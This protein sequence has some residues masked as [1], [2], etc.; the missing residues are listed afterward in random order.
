MGFV[1]NFLFW[2]PDAYTGDGQHRRYLLGTDASLVIVPET[3][4]FLPEQHE[5]L[6]T[7]TG[8]GCNNLLPS[9]FEGNFIPWFDPV[10]TTAVLIA[11]NINDVFIYVTPVQPWLCDALAALKTQRV[12]ALIFSQQSSTVPGG[13]EVL[14]WLR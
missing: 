2:P 7:E 3:L 10:I 11:L 13:H 5:Q 9:C 4:F 6:L 14:A 12:S 8:I 1:S